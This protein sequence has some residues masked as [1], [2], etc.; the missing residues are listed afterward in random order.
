MDWV[1]QYR[2]DDVR[3]LLHEG[4]WEGLYES[5][6]LIIFDTGDQFHM[7]IYEA[8]LEVE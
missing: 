5:S 3:R 7:F 4:S 8:L 2:I 6:S 1:D